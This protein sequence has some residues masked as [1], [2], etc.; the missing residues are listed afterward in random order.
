M[1]QRFMDQ[2]SGSGDDVVNRF[3]NMLF[4]KQMGYFD[5]EEFEK[6]IDFYLNHLKV[7]KSMM[8]VEE[9]LKQHPGS[10]VLLLWKARVLHKVGK[11]EAALKII[12]KSGFKVFDEE[13]LMLEGEILLRLERYQEANDVFVHLIENSNSDQDKICLDIAFLYMGI[14][15]T[16]IALTYLREGLKFNPEN[17]DILFELAL[18]YE[19]NGEA[20]YAIGYLNQLLDIDPYNEEAWFNLGMSHVS[21]EDY[22]KAIEAFDFAL[23]VDSGFYNAIFQ[24]GIALLKLD[25]YE[26]ALNAFKTYLNTESHNEEV[27]IYL[28]ECYEG[29]GDYAAA[30]HT[31]YAILDSEPEIYDAWI[32][33]GY[34]KQ[35]T[36][37]YIESVNCFKKALELNENEDEAWTGMGESYFYSGF[38]KEAS[39]AFARSLKINPLQDDVWVM[40]IALRIENNEIEQAKS[41]LNLASSLIFDNDSLNELK[42]ML[43]MLEQGSPV[44]EA[45][46]DTLKGSNPSDTK[47]IMLNLSNILDRHY[48]G[49]S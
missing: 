34:C 7:K 47:L 39:E 9:G 21:A 10:T 2:N 11:Y 17:I 49:N 38:K 37:D 28:A 48:F 13:A 45:E 22:L 1:H 24:K 19:E 16:Q 43:Q 31:Y 40:L 44:V 14:Q 20:D 6:L 35:S 15:Q 30:E 23:V 3:E 36:K 33:L 29:V 4:N 5:V 25:R 41:A 42:E 12:H 46:M 27:M 18:Y 26:D 32:G 8:V